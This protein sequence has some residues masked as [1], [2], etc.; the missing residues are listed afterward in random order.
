MSYFASGYYTGDGS[1]DTFSIPF[2]YLKESHMHVYIDGTEDTSFTFSTA[3]QVQ[4]SS[5]PADGSTVLVQRETP[6][7]REV[8]F[9]NASMLK[10]SEMDKDSNQM[11]YIVQ[12]SADEMQSAMK[13]GNDGKLDATN[14]VIKNVGDPVNDN[15]AATKSYAD[16]TV[17]Q[18]ET[19]KDQAGDSADAAAISE[20][21]AGI[22]E[23][24]AADSADAAAISETNAA[25]SADNLSEDNISEMGSEID[26]NE[27]RITTAESELDDIDSNGDGI[28]D[29]ADKLDGQHASAF[30]EATEVASGNVTGLTLDLTTIEDPYTS[31]KMHIVSLRSTYAIKYGFDGTAACG[32]LGH[33]SANGGLR[34]TLR[35]L[36][37]AE[38]Y[39]YKVWQIG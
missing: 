35:N 1:T 23:T 25:I 29:N 5:T 18:A 31:H 24:N 34:L 21:N 26:S 30:L 33:W 17:S 39:Y 11:M 13:V 16:T 19:Y 3:S 20:T 6:K 7:A 2:D 36:N 28:V 37:S 9:E 27:S 15:E 10:E 14:R 12:E 38:T 4:T 22:S 32:N 8:N